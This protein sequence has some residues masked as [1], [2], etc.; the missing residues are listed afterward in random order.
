M[1]TLSQSVYKIAIISLFIGSSSFAGMISGE[2]FVSHNPS[3]SE[4]TKA[5]TI[6]QPERTISST[7]ESKTVAEKTTTSETESTPVHH[8]SGGMLKN[9]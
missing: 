4:T 2:S 1:K 9:K 3:Q 8:F 7:E 6:T 5:E